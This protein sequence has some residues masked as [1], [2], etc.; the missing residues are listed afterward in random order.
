[1]HKK[2]ISKIFIRLVFIF[3]FFQVLRGIF[4]IWNW[5]I[6][7]QYSQGDLVESFVRSF[8]FDMATVAFVFGLWLLISLV[9]WQNRFWKFLNMLSFVGAAALIA[10]PNMADTE[11]YQFSHKRLTIDVFLM[12][13][14]I[15]RQGL[16]MLSY[17]WKLFFTFLFLVFVAYKFWQWSEK[18][19]VETK[20]VNWFV[21][22]YI[23]LF[24]PTIVVAARGGFQHRPIQPVNAYTAKAPDLGILTLNSA[25]SIVRSRISA[26][27]VHERYVDKDEDAIALIQS[28]SQSKREP[29]G[30]LKGKNVVVIVV[31]SLALEF[32]GAADNGH[33]YTPFL[34]EL[35]KKGLFFT[36]FF[37]NG[38]RSIDGL[39]SIFCEL[40]SMIDEAILTSPF[41]GNQIYCLPHAL[42][43]LGYSNVFVHGA[44]NGSMQI[45]AFANRAGFERFVGF[46]EA[47]QKPYYQESMYDGH[48]GLLD[49]P[50]FDVLIDEINQKKE[51]FLAGAFTLTS[52]HPYFIPEHLRGKFSLGTLPIHESIGYVDYSIKHFFEEASKQK[53]FNNTVFLITADHCTITDRPG[54][55]N[56][57]G[58]YRVPL[59]VY[60]PSF[61][62]P[63]VRQDRIGQHADIMPSVLDL[64]GYKAK[65]GTDFGVSLFDESI[66][67]R[68]FN[69]RHPGHWYIDSER[70]VTW[71]RETK[72]AELFKHEH[73]RNLTAIAATQPAIEDKPSEEAL[74][75]LKAFLHQFNAGALNNNWILEN[76]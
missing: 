56:D 43:P 65:R 31:E 69:K 32:V 73:T 44:H 38:R 57:L 29:L 54:Y 15:G 17:Y 16:S 13:G 12:Q 45:D 25:L 36:N 60:S 4:L 67:E 9:P 47:K 22:L 26:A 3:G 62:W 74:K 46:N 30:W 52:H 50:M 76:K 5:P 59:L 35:A 6:Y 42:K 68:A 39:P 11:F 37:A 64:I 48:W 72:K 24:I 21:A 61:Q 27:D 70:M 7:E 55:Q 2:S 34:D 18:K 1:M 51:P 33:G 8:R 20:P 53:W 23:L 63:N 75:A 28:L 14:D 58:Y 40:P 10:A 71:N 41:A 19:W 49:E 66:P